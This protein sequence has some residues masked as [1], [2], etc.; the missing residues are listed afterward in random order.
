[1]I[2]SLSNANHKFC[3]YFH[4]LNLFKYHSLWILTHCYIQIHLLFP[5]L[6]Y[7]S[8]LMLLPEFSPVT[9]MTHPLL[10]LEMRSPS[11]MILVALSTMVHLLQ[12]LSGS[13][14]F[15]DNVYTP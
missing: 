1:M 2:H 5:L 6:P 4:F 7:P 10:S 11:G 12:S 14:S 15:W 8:S 13:L 3:F 9:D